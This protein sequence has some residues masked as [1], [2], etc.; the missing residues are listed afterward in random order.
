MTISPP[1]FLNMWEKTHSKPSLTKTK[2]NTNMMSGNLTRRYRYKVTGRREGLIR[3]GTMSRRSQL[4]A[5]LAGARC[6]EKVLR[7]RFRSSLAAVAEDQGPFSVSVLEVSVPEQRV[8][9]NHELRQNRLRFESIR[10]ALYLDALQVKVDEL[11]SNNCYGCEIDHPSQRHHQCLM[12]SGE[13]R[14]SMYFDEVLLTVSHAT[15]LEK[16]REQRTSAGLD[17][18]DMY[19]LRYE[20]ELYLNAFFLTSSRKEQMEEKLKERMKEQ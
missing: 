19:V 20:N 11:C 8:F 12:L 7:N 1:V 16:A 6:L 5:Y 4:A 13:E 9:R 18:H 14:V 15:I 10:D 3:E 2:Q 17:L